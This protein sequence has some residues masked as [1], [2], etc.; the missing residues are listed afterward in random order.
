MRNL[1][2]GS[3]GTHVVE[4]DDGLLH[5][6]NTTAQLPNLQ[7]DWRVPFAWNGGMA[8]PSVRNSDGVRVSAN[9]GADVRKPVLPSAGPG[10]ARQAPSRTNQRRIVEGDN[11]E[12]I[13]PQARG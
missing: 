12:R 11:A 4:T 2:G 13:L 9:L 10:K 6:R 7:W 5:S 1:P 8:K 3:I